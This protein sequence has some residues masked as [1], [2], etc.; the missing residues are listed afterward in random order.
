MEEKQN[1]K[2]WWHYSS[3]LKKHIL[4]NITYTVVFIP[5]STSSHYCQLFQMA[6]T[7]ALLPSAFREPDSSLLVCLFVVVLSLLFFLSFIIASKVELFWIIFL[8]LHV[9]S[10]VYKL[11]GL[12]GSE[13]DGCI[14]SVPPRKH[15]L[16]SQ[17][18]C[19]CGRSSIKSV[20]LRLHRLDHRWIK[21]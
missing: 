13:T 14:L 6:L 3:T 11:E 17:Q 12:W 15:C 4:W 21:C 7:S 2:K 5:S 1:V 9:T 20:L 16:L 10:F 18:L 19:L 8:V